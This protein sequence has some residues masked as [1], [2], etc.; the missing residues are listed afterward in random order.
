MQWP[1]LLWQVPFKVKPYC[2]MG[3]VPI[4]QRQLIAPPPATVC[5]QCVKMMHWIT[6]PLKCSFS[7][8][9]LT[10]IEGNYTYNDSIIV[11][12]FSIR[13]VRAQWLPYY[14]SVFVLNA[15]KG[16]W[17]TWQLHKESNCINRSFSDTITEDLLRELYC[18]SCCKVMW[19]LV[20]E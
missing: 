16:I 4:S 14:A 3:T 6:E 5:S 9:V 7:L 18:F 19:K 13:S 1:Y 12:E 2:M 8:F 11:Q 15:T 17:M 20:R 10:T